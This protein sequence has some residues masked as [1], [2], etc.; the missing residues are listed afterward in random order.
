MKKRTI[1][2]TLSSQSI[3]DAIKQLEDY[4]KEL[5]DKTELFLEKLADIGITVAKHEAAVNDDHKFYELGMVE[6]VKE[7]QDGYLHLIGRNADLSRL[8]THWYDG[9]GNPHDET[10]SPILALEW[11]TAGRAVPG[12][13][14][15]FA[16]TGNHVNDTFWY[17]YTSL[18]EN[19][20]PDKDTKHVAT[21]VK[22]HEMM[23]KATMEM[24][25]EIKKVAKEVWG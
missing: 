13:K 24:M 3:N 10:I 18:D 7:W 6:F 19:G 8:H 17:Y 2:M 9:E 14:G 16:V 1:N 5:Q 12:H 15:E 11:G 21:A 22:P 23:Y 20:K 4:K 25:K